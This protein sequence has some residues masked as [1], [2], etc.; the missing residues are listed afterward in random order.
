[1]FRSR[2]SFLVLVAFGFVF[3]YTDAA[4]YKMPL[5]KHTSQRIQMIREGKWAAE[6][7]RQQEMKK[8]IGRQSQR[9]PEVY[10]YN[11][12]EYSGAITIGTPEQQFNVALDTGSAILW[13]LHAHCE[14]VWCPFWTSREICGPKQRFQSSASVTYKP[15]RRLWKTQYGI[16]YALGFLG[17]DIVRIGGKGGP[18]IWI[19]NTV[20]GQAM[21][22]SDAF[23]DLEIDGILG[24]GFQSTAAGEFLPP[25]ANAWNQSFLDQPVFTV[26]LQRMSNKSTIRIALNLKDNF[27]G[28][29]CT[30]G[31]VDTNNCNSDVV[32]EPL[33]S[34]THWQFTMKS[35]SLG[36]YRSDAPSYEVLS[37]TGSSFIV[38]PSMLINSIVN[39]LGARYDA[40]NDV[41][42]SNCSGLTENIKIEIGDHIYEI[43]PINYFYQITENICVLTLSS[44]DGTG[45]G[46][47]VVLGTPFL[48]QYCHV[49]DF[50]NMQI[51][52][53]KPK[54]HQ[55]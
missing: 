11:D 26:W 25:L 48:R 47:Q 53:A 17:E 7:R 37:D 27:L 34:A 12:F 2:L 3:W 15:M 41:F 8:S 18:Q 20:F 44:M 19:P 52:F 6:Y 22:I 51:G 5:R 13:V 21:K 29:I 38:G 54:I 14:R 30:W 43:E 32:Y 49:Y 35:I 24:L 39:E 23:K 42:F 10:V 16:G 50:G 28:G 4:V 46:P 55:Y 31:G 1:M 40:E 33:S 45:L 36:T 9:H